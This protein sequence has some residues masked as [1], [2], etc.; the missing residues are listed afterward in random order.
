[1]E[2]FKI[3]EDFLQISELVDTK[4]AFI[5]RSTLIDSTNRSMSNTYLNL[6]NITAEEVLFYERFFTEYFG[7]PALL[8]EKISA[9]CE[10]VLFIYETLINY[11]KKSIH[12]SNLAEKLD[13]WILGASYNDSLSIDS[14]NDVKCGANSC[15]EQSLK[16]GKICKPGLYSSSILFQ[17][18]I[19]ICNLLCYGCN[20]K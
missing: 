20:R 13:F 11:E 7:S 14:N 12:T 5:N 18:R 10:S 6:L 15:Y 3:Q 17:I 2:E 16:S 4:N 9:A 19:R 8:S 1:M